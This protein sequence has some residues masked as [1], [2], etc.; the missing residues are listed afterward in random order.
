MPRLK[1]LQADLVA[2]VIGAVVGTP[3]AMGFALIAGVNP[4]YGLYTAVVS[5]IVAALAGRSALM[6]V[7]PTNALALVVASVL[8][9]YDAAI[10]PERLFVLTSLVG[11]FLVGF[12]ILRLG[13]L[14]RFV[15]NAV[16]TGF[17]SGAGLLI[18]LGQ[19][20]YLNGYDPQGQTTLLR[21]MDWLQHLPD[22]DL[23]TV[24]VGLVAIVTI[25]AIQR[26]RFRNVAP[27]VAIVL[28]TLSVQLLAWEGV[29]RVHDISSVP[30]GLP[31][32]VLPTLTVVPE[33]A[34]A[35]L[36]MAVLAAVQ[37]A[38]LLNSIAEPG[39]E[40]SG[41]NRDF[42]GMGL[43]N[44]VG[45]V[46]RGMPACGSLS[47]TAVNINAGASTRWANVMAGVS[48]GT[49]LILLGPLVEQVV[50]AAL[51]AQLILAAVSLID[52]E[53]IRLVWRVN[54]PARTAMVVTFTATL[55]LPLQYSIYVGIFLSL[56][57]Y[58]H[59]AAE[60]L[61]VVRLVPVGDNRYQTVAIPEA[62][63]ES[64]V[65]IF[66]VHG[67]LYF[68]AVQKLASVLP[69]AET[70]NRSIVVLR[71]REN[72]FLGSTG[73]RFLQRYNHVLRQHGGRLI[74][75]GLSESVRRQFE[76]T[77]M[78]ADF[79]PANLFDASDIFLEA[80][81]SAYEYGLTLLDQEE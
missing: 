62:L 27:L 30:R 1:D 58:V 16:M 36:A 51:A 72:T 48:V 69:S 41:M 17:I 60:N 5:T 38:A 53:Q 47:R 35:A 42:V 45:G 31:D 78:Q 66:S 81:G 18:I 8:G 7:G 4:I 74:L 37:S 76:Q 79:G 40:S 73:I 56:G 9:G 57:L 55:A 29:T 12:G 75:A 23:Q 77:G 44:L 54:W 67:H 39:A 6:T 11:A 59:S 50:L 71:L 61:S 46:L 20:R 2:G 13:T 14:V 32:P 26:T 3:Q 49:F 52:L 34:T 43:G 21:F 68:A 33:L 19:F 24:A 65:V 80:T 64:A 63:P 25:F 28:T 15:S 70:G 10:Q 22:S